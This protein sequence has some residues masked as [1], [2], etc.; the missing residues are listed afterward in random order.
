VIVPSINKVA[1]MLMKW[2]SVAGVI[3]AFLS[4]VQAADIPTDM[5]IDLESLTVS[6]SELVCLALN[7]YFEA[8]GETPAGRLAVAKVVLNRAMDRRFPSDLC[9]VIKQNRSGHFLRCQFTWSCDGRPDVPYNSRAWRRSV[10][11]AVAVLQ[12]DSNFVDHTGGALWYHAA[13]ITPV[14]AQNLEVSKVFGGHIF[15]IEPQHMRRLHST[16]VLD[17]VLPD[18]HRFSKWQALRQ[19]RSATTIAQ[20]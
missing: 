18:L 8:R 10:K 6:K 16:E 20:R 5:S 19:S 15:Y 4:P 1:V 2:L 7:D 3:L 12:K 11:L 17:P 14:W 9:L 13:Y